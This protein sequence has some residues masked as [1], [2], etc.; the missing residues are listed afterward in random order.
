MSNRQTER[1]VTCI[2][3]AAFW[4]ILLCGWTT[5]LRTDVPGNS[6]DPTDVPTFIQDTKKAYQERLDVDHYFEASGASTYDDTDT[7]KH[8][9]VTFQA[10]QTIASVNA[11]EGVLFTKDTN[12][13]AELYWRDESENEKQLTSGGTINIAE[14]DIAGILLDEDDMASD[15]ASSICSQ[16]SIVAYVTSTRADDVNDYSTMIPAITGAGAGYAGEESIT[17][18]NGMILKSGVTTNGAGS[19]TVTF[20]D[21][22]PNAIISIQCTLIRQGTQKTDEEILVYPGYDTSSFTF[23]VMSNNSSNIF[24]MAT[25]Y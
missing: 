20:G 6:D 13:V 19:G 18:Q 24:W 12:S 4:L 7:G 9:Q 2:T 1:A 14:T 8:R 21:A 23:D 15:S 22:F 25:G 10:G 11:D 3:I 16:Q 17:F 5:T